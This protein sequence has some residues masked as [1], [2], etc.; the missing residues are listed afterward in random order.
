MDPFHE[1]IGL[2]AVVGHCQYSCH[3]FRRDKF[4]FDFTADMKEEAVTREASERKACLLLQPLGF[5]GP[6]NAEDGGVEAGAQGQLDFE[7]CLC[8]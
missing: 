1:V 7:G 4:C 6:G 5:A 2:I 8:K 3:L